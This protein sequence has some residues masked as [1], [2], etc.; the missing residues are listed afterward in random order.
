MDFKFEPNFEKRLTKEFFIRNTADV[1]RELLGK[2][3]I[4]KTNYNNY[5]AAAIV[6]TEAYLS[7]NDL[8]SHSAPGLTKR[9]SAMFEEGGIIYIYKIYGIHHC[10]NIV[11]EKSG[12]GAAVLLRAAMPIIG[13]D[14]FQKNR[15]VK[16]IHNLCKGPGNLTKA[17]GFNSDDNFKTLNTE[18]LFIQELIEV[19][20]EDIVQTTRIGIIKSADLQLRFYIKDNEFVSRKSYP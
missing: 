12:T 18:E 17:F 5:I 2:C 14:T 15:G 7:E 13:I 11:T 19:K 4:K 1:A 20:P 6:E 9:N 10:I 3:L 8:S 16:D